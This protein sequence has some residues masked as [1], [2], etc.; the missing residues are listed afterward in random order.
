M[1]HKSTKT[2][3][4]AALESGL[5]DWEASGAYASQHWLYACPE[6]AQWQHP[7]EKKHPSAFQR[8][9]FWSLSG[10]VFRKHSCCWLLLD[11]RVEL[12]FPSLIL[13][14]DVPCY[15]RPS[16]IKF[17]QYEWHRS[18]LPIFCSFAGGCWTHPANYLP[19]PGYSY[20]IR[21]VAVACI[22]CKRHSAST[23]QRFVLLL[24]T[25]YSRLRH[26]LWQGR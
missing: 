22:Q 14:N 24:W 3:V 15:L 12:V 26:L 2:S 11:L 8:S 19:A 9:I 16:T 5:K 10:T 13:S 7:E 18:I 17:L 4:L 6:G 20:R 21:S 1:Q 25:V 23:P